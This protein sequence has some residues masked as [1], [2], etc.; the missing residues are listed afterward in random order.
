MT[1]VGYGFVFIFLVLTGCTLPPK[2]EAVSQSGQNVSTQNVLLT[3][4]DGRDIDVR[5]FFP[6]NGCE[7]CDAVLFS[8]GAFSTYDRYDAL[9]KTWA[10]AGY[11]VLAPLH[12]DSET[13]PNRDQYTQ[14]DAFPL[15]I[16]DYETAVSMIVDDLFDEADT[17]SFSG[18][19][20]A[21]GH[22]FG[23]IIAQMA[24][25]AKPD[26]ALD[27]DVMN[28]AKIPEAIVA[29]SPPGEIPY[30]MTKA[31]WRKISRPMLLVTGTTDTLPNFVP[32]WEMRLDAHKAAPNT[33]SI[34]AIFDN[35]DHYFNGAF[36]RLKS[37]DEMSSQQMDI[38]NDLIISFVSF[39]FEGGDPVSMS[40][41]KFK[42]TNGLTI[43]LDDPEK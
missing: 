7:R 19:Y 6:E 14:Q 11:I 17:V 26:P 39:A 41:K 12:V 13:H 16:K 43:E 8:H 4:K 1:R 42:G 37:V 27:I 3:T 29:I 36:G 5:L 28:V 2:K 35:M 15:R 32:K 40:S 24:G 38:L 10:V 9:L 25:G 23:A 20:V 33:L 22:S 34:A 31:G 21:A 18:R 30:L